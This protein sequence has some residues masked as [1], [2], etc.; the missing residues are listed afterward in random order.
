MI[1]LRSDWAF[2]SFSDKLSS[3]HLLLLA[4]SLVVFEELWYL[5]LVFELDGMVMQVLQR[6]GV[7][8]HHLIRFGYSSSLDAGNRRELMLQ[9]HQLG[10]KLT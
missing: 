8:P 4:Q 3:R 5:H 6:R 7:D 10:I 2:S 1:D 9:A